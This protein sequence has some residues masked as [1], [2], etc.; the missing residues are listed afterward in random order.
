MLQTAIVVA[1]TLAAGEV[2]PPADEVPSTKRQEMAKLLVCPNGG[3]PVRQGRRAVRPDHEACPSCRQAEGGLGRPDQA[4]RPVATS[5]RNQDGED[6]AIRMV[7]VT[8]EFQRGKTRHQGRL[9]IGQQGHRAVLRSLGKI[10][11]RRP[12]PIPR[13]SRKRRSRSAK[14]SGVC[15]A[16]CR[17]RRA[18]ALFLP[19]SWCMA[20]GRTTGMKPSA[21]TSRSVI[22]PTAWRHGGLPSCVTRN[23]PSSIRS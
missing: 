1:L 15:P 6:P 21:P 3:G 16:R 23:A 5:Y 2:Q 14:A 9:R 20:L 7:F 22:W 19:W 13:S 12:T 8:C 17:C 11:G 4:I 18:L 10:P